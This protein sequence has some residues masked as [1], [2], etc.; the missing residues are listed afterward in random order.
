MAELLLDLFLY[1]TSSYPLL[2]IIGALKRIKRIIKYL[3]FPKG[4][5][6]PPVL[7]NIVDLI[8]DMK[9]SSLL[10]GISLHKKTISNILKEN[11]FSTPPMKH[12]T[13][14]WEALLAEGNE[15]CAM[16]FCNIIDLKLF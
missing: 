9:R 1:Y 3:W 15:V 10:M 4:P 2:L 7:E 13:P 8:L 16:N 5:G 11:G 12:Q 14:T 6:R